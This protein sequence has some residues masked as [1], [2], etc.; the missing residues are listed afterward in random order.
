M[1]RRIGR[2]A[3][4]TE[5]NGTELQQNIDARKRISPLKTNREL[6]IQPFKP[7]GT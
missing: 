1:G 7:G 3:S 2:L 5:W 6:K 4:Q